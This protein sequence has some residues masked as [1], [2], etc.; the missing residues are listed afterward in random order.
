MADNSR[1][2]SSTCKHF[3]TAKNRNNILAQKSS[4][5]IGV[6]NVDEAHLYDHHL[7]VWA[8]MQQDECKRLTED[9][10]R[11]KHELDT[12]KNKLPPTKLTAKQFNVEA[13]PIN[14]VE[15]ICNALVIN[16]NCTYK[17]TERCKYNGVT[18]VGHIGCLNL[19]KKSK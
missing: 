17:C 7:W 18:C 3:Y 16:G 6:K 12:M 10:I 13:D 8:S 15:G 2:D 9:N 4:N 19:V 14:Y 5:Y 1:C 11:L